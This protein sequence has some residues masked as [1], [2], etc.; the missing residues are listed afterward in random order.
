VISVSEAHRI[1]GEQFSQLPV[2]VEDTS[3][4]WAKQSVS[5]TDFVADRDLPPFNRVAMDG[6]AIRFSAMNTGRRSF[7][8]AA[9]Q[10]AGKP[11]CT[12]ED[13]SACIEV[14]TGAVLPDGTDTVIRYEDLSIH[15][16]VAT[17]HQSVDVK[18]GQ[19]V[20]LR[21]S[22]RRQGE[23]LLPAGMSL[24]STHW[25]IAA[26]VGGNNVKTKCMPRVTIIGTGD[27]LVAV[28]V[29]PLPHQIRAS[30]VYAVAAALRD[31]GVLEIRMQLAADD[32][33][34]LKEKLAAA[35]ES[36]DICIITGAVSA[37]KVD[38]V[39]AALKHIGAQELFH[40]VAQR[41]GKP[42][43]FGT[44][45]QSQTI[46][47]GLPG[48]PVS[49]LACTYRYVIPAI[50]QHFGSA[51][52]ARKLHAELTADVDFSLGETMSLF[53]PVKV[54]FREDARIVCTPVRNIGSGDLGSL[55]I[56]DGFVE[57][58]QGK[59]KFLSGEVVPLYLWSS[60]LG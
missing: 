7:R 40:K 39:P 21:G 16:H 4:E 25:A 60:R 42:L 49:T 46:V 27:E 29:K 2:R 51:Q 55:G 10:L 17:L 6:I 31:I 52:S 1:I 54:N 41:P 3:I 19:N 33:Q 11:P 47:F 24:A 30:N 34:D 56:S 23:T 8:V 9:L 53:Q 45:P 57:L 18:S 22:D 20:H 38:L 12:L 35:C 44:V 43:W 37:G 36:S 58:K 32:E 50:Q 13:P 26:T 59:T 14:M 15:E 28:G 48:N 5:T